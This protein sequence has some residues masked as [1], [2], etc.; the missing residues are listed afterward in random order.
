M[1]KF[2]QT[3]IIALKKKA[4]ENKL[5]KITALSIATG[6][7]RNTLGEILSGKSQPTATVME[8]LIVALKMTPEEAGY[9]FFKPNLRK[10]QE[11]KVR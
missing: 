5:E 11:S 4:V 3:D 7:N 2:Y 9:I 10:T 1:R 8:K 6:I